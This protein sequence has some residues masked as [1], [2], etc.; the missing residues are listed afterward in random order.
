MNDAADILVTRSCVG[1]GF[2]CKKVPCPYGERAPSTGW[3]VHLIPWAGDDL[4]VPRYR[5][6]RYEFIRTQPGWEVMPAF[7]GGCSSALFNDDRDRIVA[8][9]MKRSLP[10]IRATVEDLAQRYPWALRLWRFEDDSIAPMVRFVVPRSEWRP[11]PWVPEPDLVEW[12]VE[13]V[14][15]LIVRGHTGSLCGYIGLPSG[16]PLWGRDPMRS[17]GEQWSALPERIT[18]ARPSGA[19][20]VSTRRPADCWWLGFSAGGFC[21][22]ASRDPM[23]ESS[24]YSA[25]D[26]VRARVEALANA[27]FP[28]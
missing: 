14:P 12:H 2:C 27:L 19:V 21:P 9:L 1:S 15:L 17:R 5:C 20:F 3:C 6:G 28:L 4:G 10:L 24:E 23:P 11:G 7:G 26:E 13:D 25:I 18:A 16:H 8:T 22:A